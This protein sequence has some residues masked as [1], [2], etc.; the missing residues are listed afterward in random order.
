VLIKEVG[1]PRHSFSCQNLSLLR[2]VGTTDVST[3]SAEVRHMF[4]S[5]LRLR[6]HIQQDKRANN[7]RN[8]TYYVAVKDFSSFLV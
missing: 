8:C 2:L 5:S 4:I 6:G 7:P 3:K 1:R